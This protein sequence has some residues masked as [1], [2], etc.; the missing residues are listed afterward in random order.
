MVETCNINALNSLAKAS[1][2]I[3]EGEVLQMSLI[4]KTDITRDQYF[5]VIEAKT[6]ALFAAATEVSPILQGADVTPF[7]KYGH[8]LGMAFQIVDD[9][10]DYT[11]PKMG[12]DK[13]DDFMEGEITL[14]VIIAMESASDEDRAFLVESIQNPKQENLNN[15]IVLLEKYNAFDEAIKIAEKHSN[16][17]S[18][19]LKLHWINCRGSYYTSAVDFESRFLALNLIKIIEAS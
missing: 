10:M 8:A 13:G 2:T 6:A 7:T 19:A 17:A 18:E 9:V 12:K 16:Q 4:G 15:F 1:A 14:P 3:T 11:S 5:K